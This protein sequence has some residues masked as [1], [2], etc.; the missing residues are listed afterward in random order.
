M[1]EAP[2][3]VKYQN[4]QLILIFGTMENLRFKQNLEVLQALKCN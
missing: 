3:L 2:F 1:Q 4:N